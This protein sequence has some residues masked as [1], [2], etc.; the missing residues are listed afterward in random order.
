MIVKVLSL[1]LVYVMYHVCMSLCGLSAMFSQFAGLGMVLVSFSHM[2][3]AKTYC[4]CLPQ[5][6]SSLL[7]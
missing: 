3:L 1:T 6:M 7:L 2:L 5:E 4:C